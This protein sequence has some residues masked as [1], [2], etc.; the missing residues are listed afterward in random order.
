M[1]NGSCLCKEV[2]FS[3][4]GNI[5]DIGHCHCSKCRKVSGVNSNGVVLA[6]AKRFKWES[7]KD[8]V[9]R[10]EMAD[11]WGSAFCGQCGCPVPMPMPNGKLVW[12]PIG[13]LDEHPT[14]KVVE[15]IYVESKAPWE[16]I[17]DDAPQHKEDR[18]DA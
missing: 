9:R 2:R 17:G 15:H 13:S 10:Y 4:D 14:L 5:S 6:A 1:V 11:G 8:L 12:I 16:V 18:D 3:V 7:G